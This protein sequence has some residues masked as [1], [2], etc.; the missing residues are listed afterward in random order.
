MTQ[1]VAYA[2]DTDSRRGQ[3]FPP[4]PAE[5]VE[6]L[7]AA[8]S[9]QTFEDGAI[10]YDLG[11]TGVP[12]YVVL[13]GALE[14]VHRH[15]GAEE[16][17]TVHHEREFSGE[18]SMLSG[19]PA[20]VRGRARGR[21]RVL[22]IEADRFRALMQTDAELSE[23]AMRAYILR[24]V[25]LVAAGFGDV[26]VVG[27]SHSAATTRVQDFLT[28]NGHPYHYVDLERDTDVEELLGHARVAP[29]EIPLV[30]CSDGS[31]LRN[32]SNAD[33][34]D[35][36]G[37]NA[38][39]EPG[40]IHDVVICGAGLGGLA[41]AVYAGSEG[42]DVLVVE[43]NAPGG[44]AATSSKIENY[45]GFPTGITG[46]SLAQRAL[47]Q[48]EKFGARIA[49]AHGA[50]KL[51]CA[52]RGA[53]EVDLAGGRRVQARA[54]IIATG[55]EY[56][57]LELPELARF[58]GVGVYYAATFLEAQRCATDDVI[59]VGGANSAGQA[60]TFLARGARHV[61]VLVRGPDLAAT[62]SR[63]LIRRIEDTPNITLHRRTQ[64]VGLHGGDRLERVTWRDDAT[65]EESTHAIGH[66]FSMTGA[67]PNT[68]W[69]G[70]CVAMDANGFVR[71][72]SELTDELLAERGWPLK[73]RPYLF[74]TSRPRVFAVGDVRATS[75]KRVASA[76]GE[77]SVCIQLVHKALAEPA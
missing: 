19:R 59:V 64:I 22:R 47:N 21:L 66:V 14:V 71:T 73:R 49:I 62:M 5:V 29:D 11:D 6:R 31:M 45:L 30:I 15:G 4:L 75:V 42:L 25:G 67:S 20:L 24:R 18:L 3:M 27:S 1:G 55:A 76:V 37:F 50:V 70:D 60:A 54:I 43:A 8:G 61:H 23:I 52:G 65:G 13:D 10:V 33:I 17:V 26:T 35:C 9:E 12:F 36:L 40:V 51:H 48:A 44:Q 2:F 72:D 28:R 58:E 7:A 53:M 39:I 74:E 69:L 41:A 63:Y 46:Q 34:A 68:A 77:G 56:R 16:P 38:A 57:K 32:P